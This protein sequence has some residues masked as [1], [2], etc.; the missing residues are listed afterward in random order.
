MGLDDQHFRLVSLGD[1][2]ELLAEGWRIEKMQYAD[3]SEPSGPPAARIVLISEPKRKRRPSKRQNRGFW[4]KRS[5][6]S[7]SLR[8]RESQMAKANIPRR[9]S[10]TRSPRSSWSGRLTGT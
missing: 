10:T 7:R 3:R 2:M 8:R 6:A 1:L 5:R 4:P 9:S